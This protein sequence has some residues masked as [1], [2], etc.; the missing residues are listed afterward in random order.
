M[1]TTY[2]RLLGIL[3]IHFKHNILISIRLQHPET[4]WFQRHWILQFLQYFDR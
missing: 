2:I 4:F 1:V 3:N